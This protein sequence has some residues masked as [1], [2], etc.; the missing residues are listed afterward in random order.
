M[1]QQSIVMDDLSVQYYKYQ[2]LHARQI[3][4]IKINRAGDAH[5]LDLIEVELITRD[6]ED[7]HF[8]ALSYTWG[9][10]TFEDE[11][12]ARCQVFTTVERCYPVFSANGTILRVTKSLRDALRKLRYFEHPRV[13]QAFE[14]QAERKRLPY[15]WADGVCINQDD[16]RE[17]AQQVALMGEIYT[18]AKTIFAYVGELGVEGASALEMGRSLRKLIDLANKPRTASTSFMSTFNDPDFFKRAGLRKPEEQQWRDWAKFLARPWFRRTWVVQETFLAGLFNTY[19]LCGTKLVEL[20]DLLN[21]ITVVER[22]KWL[23]PVTTTVWGDDDPK[24]KEQRDTIM[25]WLQLGHPYAAVIQSLS[26]KTPMSFRE[27]SQRILPRTSC[28]DPRDYVYATLGF[29]KEWQSR[30]KDLMPVDY[31]IGAPEVFM[32]ATHHLISTSRNLYMLSCVKPPDSHEGKEPMPGLPSWCVDYSARNSRFRSLTESYRNTEVPVWSASGH[33][34][35]H[36]YLATGTS[37]RG[38][39]VRGSRCEVIG[40]FAPV[41]MFLDHFE[42]WPDVLRLLRDALREQTEVHSRHSPVESINDANA[43]YAAKQLLSA[44][45]PRVLL[46]YSDDLDIEGNW[47]RTFEQHKSQMSRACTMSLGNTIRYNFSSATDSELSGLRTILNVMS[48]LVHDI[49]HLDQSM[50]AYLP[51]VAALEYLA[52]QRDSLSMTDVLQAI[53]PATMHSESIAAQQME[54]N[55]ST[56]ERISSTCVQ[57]RL[58]A[59]HGS[60]LGV[61]PY[62]LEIGDEVWLLAGSQVP[63]ILRS[64]GDGYRLIGEAYMDGAMTGELWPSNESSLTRIT[65]R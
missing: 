8:D 12:Y 33:S 55:L 59:T 27:V 39:I 5:S 24:W 49:E 61:G 6:V 3:R 14:Q 65:L 17:R 52:N 20:V 63:L 31:T 48:Q 26:R 21:G 45:L 34:E 7:V 60:R 37:L 28:S 23:L 42:L 13:A 62:T 16:L 64:H 22:L 46:A 15:I 30:D 29:A 10:P 9:P 35:H 53:A 19:I 18:R 56:G 50:L 43:K 51:D 25:A 4:L 32:R 36:P 47:E 40:S 54:N 41:H 58:F 1:L 57:R 11:E 38:L 2:K 44:S